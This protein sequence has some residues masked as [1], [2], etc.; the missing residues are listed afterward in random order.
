MDTDH[1][2]P[3]DGNGSC[4]GRQLLLLVNGYPPMPRVL[5]FAKYL[6][7]SGWFPT[8]LSPRS[9]SSAD[10]RFAGRGELDVPFVQT[11]FFPVPATW[12]RWAVQRVR[13]VAAV[14]QGSSTRRS[15]PNSARA[16]SGIASTIRRLLL[17]T[18]APDDLA[19]WIPWAVA[20]GTTLAYLRK[21]RAIVASGPPFSVV[22]SGAVL[23][24]I[25][26]LPFIADFRDAWVGDSVDPFGC[27]AGTF[28]APVSDGRRNMLAQLER[29]VISRA[30]AVLFTSDYTFERYRRIYPEVE[31]KGVVAY[32]GAE[33]SDFLSPPDT[34]VPYA[35]T[36]VGTLHEYQREQLGLFL[37]AFALSVRREKG[38]AASQVRIYGH[39]PEGLDHYIESVTREAGIEDKVTRGGT[40]Q[41]SLAVSLMKGRGVLLVFSGESRFTRPSKISDYLAVQRPI[42]ALGTEDSETARHVR[43]FGHWLY[44]GSSAEELAGLIMYLWR[45]HQHDEPPPDTFPFPYPHPLNW[46]TA[47]RTLA[48]TLDRLVR[49]AKCPENPGG[50]GRVGPRSGRINH[51]G[52]LG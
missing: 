35:F 1:S 47:A 26:G 31:V 41:H 45:L 51:I 9:R 46:R 50:V 18:S 38:L 23:R 28:R 44:S 2:L 6:P 49:E 34:S 29:H 48:E 36:Y 13:A 30:D 52:K 43:E 15:D 11:P 17:R 39:R 27:V 25:T 42:L 3:E 24:G 4:R 21:M 37:R 14:S 10:Y 19:G 7:A 40:I 16:Q 20:Y 8:V 32:N 12:A 33:E 22:V 5:K